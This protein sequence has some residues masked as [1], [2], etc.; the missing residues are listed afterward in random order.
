MAE[1]D[2]ETQ[3]DIALE[4]D[5]VVDTPDRVE[6]NLVVEFELVRDLGYSGLLHGGHVVVPPV[7]PLAWPAPVG[8]PAEVSGEDVR[9]EPLLEAVQ[10]V[11]ADE[12]HLPAQA[13]PVA[14]EP[15]V[16]R[17]GRDGRRKL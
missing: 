12:V 2:A 17:E 10:L 5:V 8:S 1:R 7:D 6:R 16:V 3:G 15:E 13:G 11:G 9:R 4:A 14:L